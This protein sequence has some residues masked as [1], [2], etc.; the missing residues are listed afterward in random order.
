MV[1]RVAVVGAGF[2]G[3][4]HARAY[5]RRPD[6]EVAAIVSRGSERG[7]ALA[8]ELGAAH[9]DDLAPVLDDPTVEIVDVCYPRHALE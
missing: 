9:L 7:A 2:M 3:G 4:V 8:A 6:V 1:L 5:A